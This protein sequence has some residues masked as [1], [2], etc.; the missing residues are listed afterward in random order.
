[1][2]VALA[3]IALAWLVYGLEVIPARVFTSNPVG[4]ALY[5]VILNKFYLDEFYAF[6]IKYII[7][8]LSNGAVLFDKYVVDGIVNGSAASV[9]RIGDAT[10]RT[11]TG[12][13]QNY[14]AAI[15]GGALIIALAVFIATG[16]FVR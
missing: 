14:G 3:G 12:V 1:V 15:F 11:E 9:R 2:A 4:R 7:L 10:R 8:A 5:T 13:L 16:A 6:L